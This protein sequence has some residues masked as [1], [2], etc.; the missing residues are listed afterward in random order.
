MPR[1]SDKRERLIRSADELILRQG[2]K[3]TTLQDIAQD[4]GVPLGN[5]YYY[6]KTKED[7]G[8][9]IIQSR[10]EKMEELLADCSKQATPQER[11]LKLL[12]YPVKARLTLAESGC[13]LGTLAYELSRS[14]NVLGSYS[15][16]L[17][18]VLLDWSTHQ[19][20]QMGRSDYQALGLQFVSNLQ[21][22]T[23]IS[24]T[25]D[26]PGIIDQMVVRT[27]EWILSL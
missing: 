7:I 11:L 4:S 6:F 25:L 20:Q 17:I 5:V 8:K 16:K 14:D 9:T 12:E 2:F 13:P 23:L 22:M 3:Q 18:E 21:G 15:H 10:I 26:D 27:R 19:F 24:N 1:S